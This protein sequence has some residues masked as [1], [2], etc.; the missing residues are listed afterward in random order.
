[1]RHCVLHLLKTG[2]VGCKVSRD[3]HWLV[4]YAL[5]IRTAHLLI[6]LQRLLVIV[7]SDLF[8]IVL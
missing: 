5:V 3:G 6:Q 2:I 8:L 1:M 7:V 4:V